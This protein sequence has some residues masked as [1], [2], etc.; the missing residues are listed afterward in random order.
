VAPLCEALVRA[1]GE[2]VIAVDSKGDI[3]TLWTSHRTEQLESGAAMTGWR[4]SDLLGEEAESTCVGSSGRVLESGKSRDHV[5]SVES[6]DGTRWFLFRALPASDASGQAKGL[7]LIARDVTWTKVQTDRL[8]HSEALLEQAEEIANLGVWEFDFGTGEVRLSRHLLRLYQID[9]QEEWTEEMFFGNVCDEE[10]Q[11]AKQIVQ[12]ARA[13]CGSFGFASRYRMRDGRTRVHTVRGI[14]VRGE[15]GQPV[16]AI[17]VLQDITDQARAAED[18]ERLSHAL[19]QARDEERRNAARELHETAGQS[20]A[21]LKMSLGR[22]R[23]SLP[24]K[25]CAPALAL[26]DSCFELADEAAREVRTISYLMHPPLLDEVGLGPALRWYAD[27]FTRRSKISVDVDIDENLGRLPQDHETTIF[28]IVQE[29]LTNVHRYSGSRMALIRLSRNDGHV[30]AEICDKGCGLPSPSVRG[31]NEPLGVG[32]SGMRERVKQ[33]NGT[34]EIASAP[35]RGTSI[36]VVLPI[37][38][39]NN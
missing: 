8:L 10:Q 22:L 14:H 12:Q 34:F 16:R 2:F 26:L 19:M 35:G 18:L 27:G 5:F 30:R 33:L 3:Q 39:S 20:I 7:I 38:H 36:C 25:G 32:I 17:G 9:S 29:A 4:L 23:E 11:R 1:F 13:A 37:P 21:A 31:R 28:R 6:H 24:E 15:D